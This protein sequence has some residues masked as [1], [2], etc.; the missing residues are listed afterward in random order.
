MSE[1]LYPG[2]LPADLGFL[3]TTAHLVDLLLMVAGRE[4]SALFATGHVLEFY[5]HSPP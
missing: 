2:H 3:P 5:A 1:V 4:P